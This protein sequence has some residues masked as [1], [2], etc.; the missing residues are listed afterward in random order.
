[1][2]V[3]RKAEPGQRGGDLGQS[4][5]INIMRVVEIP[6]AWYAADLP[7]PDCSVGVGDLLP[8]FD[9]EHGPGVNGVIRDEREQLGHRANVL[10]DHAGLHGLAETLPLVLVVNSVAWICRP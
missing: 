9:T 4:V 3:A 2:V 8:R 10:V 1:M 7:E 6:P 5:V